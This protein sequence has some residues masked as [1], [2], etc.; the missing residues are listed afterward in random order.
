MD[1][2]RRR[3]LIRPAFR[4][5]ACNARIVIVGRVATQA[6]ITRA[7]LRSPISL[8]LAAGTPRSRRRSPPLLA[9]RLDIGLRQRVSASCLSR[10]ELVLYQTRSTADRTA[11]TLPATSTGRTMVALVSGQSNAGNSGETRGPL[12]RGR[13]AWREVAAIRALGLNAPI[14]VAR[15]A[16]RQGSSRGRAPSPRFRR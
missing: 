15:D 10:N 11:V 13:P 1:R 6:A 5:I 4:G 2:F 14:Y 16:L 7:A 9:V 3:D 8:R 12:A